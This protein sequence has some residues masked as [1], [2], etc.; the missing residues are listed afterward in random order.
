MA[1]AEIDKGT[2]PELKALAEDIIDA[3]QREITE[4][5]EHLNGGTDD[6]GSMD[7]MD[8]G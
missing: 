8:H 1:R 5:R 2:D 6:D 7:G 3:E 4:M